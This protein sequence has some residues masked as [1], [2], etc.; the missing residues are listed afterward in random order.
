M[1]ISELMSRDVVTIGP[2]ES[3]LDAV[4]RMPPECAEVIVPYP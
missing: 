4:V 1:K 3:C 2:A